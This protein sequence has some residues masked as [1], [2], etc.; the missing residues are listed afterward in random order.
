M[1]QCALIIFFFAET[2]IENLKVELS[3]QSTVT[4]GIH[5]CNCIQVEGHNSLRLLD[6]FS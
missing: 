1:M 6:L 5:V 4:E 3:V 2:Q